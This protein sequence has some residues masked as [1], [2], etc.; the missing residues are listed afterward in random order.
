MFAE[1]LRRYLSPLNIE[2]SDK[3]VS[4]LE[5]H[6]DLMTRW[7]KVL[8]LT[9]IE[10]VDAA[11]R[12]HYCESIFL[13]I[14]LPNRPLKIVDIGAGAG[15]PGIPVAVIR[16][17]CSVWLVES[18]QRKSAFLREATRRLPKVRVVPKRAEELSEA[19]DWAI[20][21]AVGYREIEAALNRLAPNV[22]L[23]AGEENPSVRFTWNKTKLPWGEHR[24]LWLGSST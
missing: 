19:F 9:R 17:D 2:L 22:A 16:P 3:Q 13:G 14:H 1:A 12:R 15:F 6:F 5:E 4:Q 21:R 18:H 23:L 24:F 10:K 20:S 7:N 8:N 11:V